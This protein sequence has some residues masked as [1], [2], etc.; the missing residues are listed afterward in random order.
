MAL[1]VTCCICDKN[2]PPPFF[3]SNDIEYAIGG[4]ICIKCAGLEYDEFLLLLKILKGLPYE[5]TYN[6][7][8]NLWHEKVNEAMITFL[9]YKKNKNS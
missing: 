6:D 7:I 5:I 1:I 8:G 3:N 2:T 4:S 9:K